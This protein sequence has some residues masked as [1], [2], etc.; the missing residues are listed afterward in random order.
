M[1]EAM[2]RAGILREQGP[3]ILWK[4]RLVENLTK[5]VP[6]VGV[7]LRLTSRLDAVIPQGWHIRPEQRMVIGDDGE[8]EPGITVV[9]GT[10]DDYPDRHPNTTDL[11]LIVE[12]AD[13]TLDEDQG[14]VLETYASHG[15]PVYW[16]ANIRAR[17]L[18]MHTEPSG[19]GPKPVYRSVRHFGTGESIPVILDGQ[20][21][22]RIAVAN[23]FP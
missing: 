16:I 14:E 5:G 9:R 7:L 10:L 20:D 11:A 1:Y 21:V 19:P 3:V 18:E 2:G 15:I 23:I 22:G 12:V 13:S 8:P 17:R 6:H 4:G